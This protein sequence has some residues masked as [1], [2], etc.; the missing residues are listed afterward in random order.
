MKALG[1]SDMEI[2]SLLSMIKPDHIQR[3]SVTKVQ[4]E[5][6]CRLA[7]QR[8]VPFGDVIHAILARDHEAILVSR[9]EKDFRKLKDVTNF[10]EP[11]E[12]I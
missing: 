4:F 12:L 6:A 5:E 11:K 8:D 7:K 2:N 10:R 9:D 3:V 1:L